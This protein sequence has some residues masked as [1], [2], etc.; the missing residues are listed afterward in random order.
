[1]D[2][3]AWIQQLNVA[4]EASD[5]SGI[6][7]WGEDFVEAVERD[8]EYVP[9]QPAKQILTLLQDY[10]RFPLLRTIGELTG[11][12]NREIEL[13]RRLAQS[14]IEMGDV[15][16]A[17]GNLLDLL[18]EAKGNLEVDPS[19]DQVLEHKQLRK[20]LPEIEGLLGR[21]YKKLYVDARPTR[22]A[23]RV[24]DYQRAHDYYLQAYKA[25]GG[26]VFHG[27]NLIALEAFRDTVTQDV[28][29]TNNPVLQAHAD[30]ILSAIDDQTRDPWELASRAE[31]LLAKGRNGEA[32]SALEA[33]LK[34]EKTTVFMV[35]S[36]RRQFREMWRLTP[37]VPPGKTIL[38]M[39]DA[40]YAQ[41]G[42]PLD[43]ERMLQSGVDLESVL[44]DTR[45]QPLEW[46][47]TALA[48]ARSIA[49]V[50]RKPQRATTRQASGTGFLVDGSKI[51]DSLNGL[52]LLLTNAHV[53]TS[54]NEVRERYP[55]LDA[56]PIE[57]TRVAFLEGGGGVSKSIGVVKE[58]YT[59]PPMEFDATLLQLESKPGGVTAAPLAEDDVVKNDRVNILGHPGGDEMAVSLQDNRVIK[60]E[61]PKLFYRT[62]T[63]HGSSGSPIFD[64][65]W[66]LVGLHHAG[67][68]F[69][70]SG[71]NEG[72]LMESVFAAIRAKLDRI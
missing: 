65:A 4:L 60:V 19:P 28:L 59:S 24:E 41:K 9:T 61:A 36:T 48:R 66:R 51:H 23:P 10:A 21:A 69:S 44:A 55:T 58:W 11:R 32:R 12:R 18:A 39:L 52:P 47:R 37:D 63:E 38:P 29:F 46:L 14:L 34:H 40:I 50:G 54:M 27:V 70:K 67:P 49:R 53:A 1:M 57:E 35:Q 6:V 62:P 68:D 64:Q 56:L 71:A 20:E 45:F 7:R 26:G 42:G 2:W 16:L 15:T 22:Q 25:E 72:L 8:D 17:I 31:A 13:R 43:I 30:S 5:E 3:G 33:Y